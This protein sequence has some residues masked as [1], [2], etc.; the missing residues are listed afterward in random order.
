MLGAPRGTAA[1][2]SKVGAKVVFKLNNAFLLSILL[3]FGRGIGT[4]TGGPGSLLILPNAVLSH[5]CAEQKWEWLHTLETQLVVG[6]EA[7]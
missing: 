3:W 5:T 6:T 7:K 4:C 1:A 2:C